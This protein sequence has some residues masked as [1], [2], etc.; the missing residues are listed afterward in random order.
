MNNCLNQ[1]FQNK[2][3]RAHKVQGPIK[4]NKFEKQ[5]TNRFATLLVLFVVLNV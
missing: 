4:Y 1:D 2:T 3:Q 5:T